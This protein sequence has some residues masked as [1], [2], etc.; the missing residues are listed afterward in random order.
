LI[1]VDLYQV[2][3]PV[4]VDNAFIL[5]KTKALSHELIIY[6]AFQQ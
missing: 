5:E 2:A 1:L 3:N 4:S 6:D